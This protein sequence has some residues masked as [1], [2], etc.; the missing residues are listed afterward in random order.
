MESYTRL[1]DGGRSQESQPAFTPPFSSEYD[2]RQSTVTR[3]RNWWAERV[4]GTPA[5]QSPVSGYLTLIPLSGRHLETCSAFA[6]WMNMCAPG[7]AC[8]QGQ[9]TCVVVADERLKP[10]RTK[11]L[12]GGLV[13][14]LCLPPVP[15][16]RLA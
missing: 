16:L 10:R 2:Q 8:S 11:L 5:R 7:S 3:L 12:V 1:A 9:H 13:C 15:Q 6:N 14:A 4:R